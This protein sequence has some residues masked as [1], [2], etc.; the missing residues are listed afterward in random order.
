MREFISLLQ[1]WISPIRP[2]L[3]LP[4]K[5]LCLVPFFGGTACSLEHKELPV[6]GQSCFLCKFTSR[7]AW[8]WSPEL[9]IRW[10]SCIS[11][12]FFLSFF[13]FVVKAWSSFCIVVGYIHRDSY[14]MRWGLCALHHG[15]QNSMEA[16][17]ACYPARSTEWLDWVAKPCE[18][19]RMRTSPIGQTSTWRSCPAH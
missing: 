15:I 3:D 11:F 14:S 13:F 19:W 6:F 9:F 12:L 4:T 7:L 5:S 2:G 10:A 16:I 17:L 18:G 1:T 8:P